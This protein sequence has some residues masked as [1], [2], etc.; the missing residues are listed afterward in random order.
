VTDQVAAAKQAARAVWAAGDFDEVYRRTVAPVGERIVEHVGV[1][2][3]DE[4]LDVACGSGNAALPA[5]A[6]G[7]RVVGLDITPELLEAGRRNAAAAGVEIEWVEGDAEEL[8]YEDASFDVVVSTF[9]CMF[10]PRHAVAAAE[11]ARVLR[12]GGRLGLCNWTTDGAI[13]EF[14]KTMVTHVGAPPPPEPPVLWGGEDHVRGLLGA[15]GIELDLR[16]EI[17]E[18]RF[19]SAEDAVELMATKFGPLVMARAALEPQGRWEAL[20]DALLEM[21]A[22]HTGESGVVF[23]AEYLVVLGRKPR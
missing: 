12:P 17:V 7:A 22:R 16:R 5:A 1:G 10:A 6:A 14:F 21:Y 18:M 4:V 19:P 15:H 9:G 8:P 11:L 23:P 13:G 20:R 3:E 2:P